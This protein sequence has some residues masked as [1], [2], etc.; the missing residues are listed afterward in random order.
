MQE[1]VSFFFYFN[2][3]NMLETAAHNI[4]LRTET[5]NPCQLKHIIF[6]AISDVPLFNI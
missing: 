1:Y 5:V 2:T 4:F 6:S 3:E